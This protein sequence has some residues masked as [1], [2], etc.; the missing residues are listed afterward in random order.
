MNQTIDK[1]VKERFLTIYNSAINKAEKYFN[2]TITPQLQGKNTFETIHKFIELDKTIS[3][4]KKDINFITYEKNATNKD[5][6]IKLFATRTTLLNVDDSE[7]LSRAVYL[8]TLSKLLADAKHELKKSIPDFTFDD[9]TNG[10]IDPLYS[11]VKYKWYIKDQED[12][13][14]IKLWQ[15]EKILNIVSFEAVKFI[16]KIQGILLKESSALEVISKD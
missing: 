5:W 12:A 6:L 7:D 11:E 14:K 16:T 10:K 13:N 8:G 15:A 3:N 4:D 9:F 2:E 1:M